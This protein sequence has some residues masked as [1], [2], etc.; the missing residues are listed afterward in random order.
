MMT[1]IIIIIMKDGYA[2]YIKITFNNKINNK[3]LKTSR[4]ASRIRVKFSSSENK[5]DITALY[6]KEV[7]WL[8]KSLVVRKP[9]FGVSDQ[10]RHKPGCTATEDS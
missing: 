6:R 10:V 3:P 4:K 9:V 7:S 5:I 2:N 8:Y 1:I